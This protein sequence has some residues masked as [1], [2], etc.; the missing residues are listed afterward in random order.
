MNK[1]SALFLVFFKFYVVFSFT[2]GTTYRAKYI[3]NTS[4]TYHTFDGEYNLDYIN[5]E[6]IFRNISIPAEEIL[7]ENGVN[8]MIAKPG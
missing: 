6:S 4:L 8:S 2:Q 3:V 5:H 7:V 1:K